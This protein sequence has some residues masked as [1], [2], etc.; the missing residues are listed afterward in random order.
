MLP[1]RRTALHAMCTV[2]LAVSLLRP[3]FSLGQEKPLDTAAIERLTGTKDEFNEKEG[4][5]TVRAP[6]T[7]LDVRVAGVQL[8]PP[9]GLT[10]WAAFQRT[11][12]HTMVMGDMVLLEDG[13]FCSNRSGCQ[14]FALAMTSFHGVPY[15]HGHAPDFTTRTLG[16]NPT[17]H[18]GLY[19]IT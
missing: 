6:R 8:T 11:G 13:Y 3:G 14:N 5:F 2:L 10:S 15:G 1:R 7:D 9:L 16:P 4:V 17:R 18:S 12:D 19:S